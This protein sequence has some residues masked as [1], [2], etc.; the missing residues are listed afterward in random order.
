MAGGPPS[1]G[2]AALGLHG[3]RRK[4]L[5]DCSEP[6]REVTRDIEN[7][8]RILVRL[9]FKEPVEIGPLE[10]KQA[11]VVNRSNRG[12]ASDAFYDRHLAQK[13]F[14]AQN[15]KSGFVSLRQMFDD[16]HTAGENYEHT[17]T[18]LA[19]PHN[20]VAGTKGS[21]FN[22]TRNFGQCRGIKPGENRD[23]S[24]KI[25]TRFSCNHNGRL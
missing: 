23:T 3:Y 4:L 18:G 14:W 25:L 19:F 5:I 22:G 21:F 7:H 1:G 11:G 2:P 8:N 15:G 6:S 13:I 16:F 9:T 20:D 10:R 24:Q 12:R 17:I